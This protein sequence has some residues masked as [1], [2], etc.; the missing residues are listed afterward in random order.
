MPALKYLDYQ[1]VKSDHLS[2]VWTIV[3]SND[4][5][6]GSDGRVLFFVSCCR[7]VFL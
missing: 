7:G 3:L 5:D 4:R 2:E 6:S 1:E